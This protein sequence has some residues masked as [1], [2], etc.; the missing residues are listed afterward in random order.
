MTKKQ[1]IT[2]DCTL[3]ATIRLKPLLN[4]SLNVAKDEKGSKS[5]RYHHKYKILK[6]SF[7]LNNH[8]QLK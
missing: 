8:K 3:A 1:Y 2:A 6:P 5:K 4:E 7:S